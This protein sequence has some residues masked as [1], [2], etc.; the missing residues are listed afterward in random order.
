MK[1]KQIEQAKKK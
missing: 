1:A